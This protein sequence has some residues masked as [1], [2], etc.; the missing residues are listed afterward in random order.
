MNQ[1]RNSIIKSYKIDRYLIRIMQKENQ[2]IADFNNYFVNLWTQKNREIIDVE[3]IKTLRNKMT[4]KIFF[5]VIKKIIQ[6][7][8]YVTLL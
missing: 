5:E 2:T 4:K 6:F 3:R 1:I 7:I 8:I